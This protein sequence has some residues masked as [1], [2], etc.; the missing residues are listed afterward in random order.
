MYDTLQLRVGGRVQSVTEYFPVYPTCSK[1]P[2]DHRCVVLE[3]VKPIREYSNRIHFVHAV[4]Q[5]Q[6][7]VFYSILCDNRHTTN[8]DGITCELAGFGVLTALL[9]CLY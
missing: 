6:A 8:V 5:T 4:S 7:N 2:H 3:P 1:N 9:R